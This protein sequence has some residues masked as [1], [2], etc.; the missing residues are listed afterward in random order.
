[1]FAVVNHLQFNRPVDNFG[2]SIQHDGI[3]LLLKLEGFID[4]YFVKVDEFNAIAILIWEDPASALAGAKTFGQAW[5]APN[6]KPFLAGGENRSTG[7]II[8]SAFGHS[9][10]TKRTSK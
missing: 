10:P 8:A 6:L 3:P 4:F 7:E 1:M 5:F 2:E 9:V